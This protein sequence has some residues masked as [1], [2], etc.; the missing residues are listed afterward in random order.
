MNC[1]ACGFEN[2]DG[3]KFC[4]KCAAALVMSCPSC[5]SESP[6]G[7][8][9]CGSCGSPLTEAIPPSRIGPDMSGRSAQ[10]AAAADDPPSSFADGRY[11]VTKFLGEGG[12]KLVYLA[13]DDTLDRDVAFALI[14]TEGLDETSRT[15][16]TREAQAMGR[17]GTHPHVVTVFDLGEHD[18]QPYI[19]TELMG[20]GDV[21]GVIEDSDHDHLPPEQ[22][23]EIAKATCRGLE[24]AHSKGIVHRDLKP[25]NVWLTED[26]TA[27]I[28]D[29]G[30]AVAT[31]RSRLTQEGMMVGTVSYM[32]P[33]QAM[34]G[35]VT[36]QADL[37]SLG[38][39]LY[40]MVTG[41]PPFVGDDS[42][43]IIG[44][45][46]NTPPVAPTWHNPDVPPALE[47]LVLR[48]LEKDPASRPS[49]AAQVRESLEAIDVGAHG[50]APLPGD[51][52]PAGPDPTYRHTF[53][54]REAELRQLH[55]A[56]D[57][58]MSGEGSLVMVVGE[59][60]IGKTTICEQLET[61]AKLRGGMTL[62]GHCYEEGSL[63]LPY[64][65]FVEAMRSYVLERDADGL[66][67]DLGSGASEVARIVSE[68]RERLDV[69]PSDPGDPE[70]DRYRLMQSVTSFLTNAATVQPLVIVLEDLHDADRGT[71]DMLTHVSR[72][73]SG[74]RL[75]LIG[76]YRDVE[77][78]R[79]HPLSSALA[80]LRRIASFDRIGLRGL[81][82]DEVQR[83]MA[84]IAGHDIQWSI[85]EAVYRQTE[86][87]PLFVQ[88]VLRYLV[89]EG[90]LA[91][92]HDGSERQTPPEMRIPEG[93]LDVIGKRL[94]R[95]SQECN[96]VLGLAAV[97]GREFPVDVLQR[98]AGLADDDLFTALEEA[99]G[100][101]V[102][103]ERSAVGAV[104]SFRFTHAFFRQTLYE[105]TI[106]PRRIRLHQQVA[107]ALEE[108]YRVRP[109]EHAVELAEHFSYSSDASDLAKAIH[110]GELAADRAMAVYSYTEAVGH[111]ERALEVQEVLDPDDQAKRCDL[112]LA[113]GRAAIS[114]GQPMRVPETLAPEALDLAEA[115]GDRARAFAACRMAMDGL[116]MYG[117]GGLGGGPEWRP[118][119]ERA[120]ELAEPGTSERV[121]TD[122]A[123]SQMSLVERRLDEAWELR[124]G[125]LELARQLGEPGDISTAAMG[126]LTPRWAPKYQR[127]QS[128][129]AMELADIV[130]ELLDV[131]QG[132]VN[133]QVLIWAHLIAQGDRD[134]AET[135]SDVIFEVAER[136]QDPG[137]L[138]GSAIVK[139]LEATL[140]GRLEE[141]VVIAESIATMGEAHGRELAGI[142]LAAVVSGGLR[143][144]LGRAQEALEA[145]DSLPELLT[146]T[147]R[148]SV[149]A[150]LVAEVG[151]KAE[152]KAA[153]EQAVNEESTLLQGDEAPT[154]LLVTL[155]AAALIVNDRPTVKLAAGKL[156]A[157]DHLSAIPGALVCPARLLGGA[158][159]L[160]N[161]Q[162]EARELYRQALKL[163]EGMRNR[164]EVALT[165]LEL[166]ELLLDHYPDDPSTEP[167]LSS[168]KGSGQVR[169]EALEHLD[170]AITEL[171]DMKMQPALERALS[172]RE[173]LRA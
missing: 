152:A 125:A 50:R 86:G 11:Q 16:I 153:I 65:A 74:S 84:A 8:K 55:T 20:G 104:V 34:G 13:H 29:F 77:V 103:E 98:V 100:A 158:A 33:E 162:D 170:L 26:G 134:R 110:F 165:R 87:N 79:S 25:G 95:L 27:K 146:A 149:R 58:A 19:V 166:A 18:G 163:S 82:A 54:G 122:W 164:P 118:W 106:A 97:I 91:R 117:Q 80:E 70:Q 123:M 144:L 76:T 116:H 139:A 6:P 22:A 135:V 136:T 28:G 133:T 141:A 56:F 40:E 43:A 62:V 78:D 155:L 129:L 15:R 138:M 126:L 105:E 161:Q 37:Y 71:L 42:V 107:R 17:L 38:A 49:S 68:V 21:E 89:E 173:I 63:S 132:S 142:G 102:V 148:A 108:R 3:M 52:A 121:Y 69:D 47:T 60:G 72:N 169:A 75:M 51:A 93:L 124:Y 147:G 53:V 7:F 112:L 109:E 36:A 4:G 167:A 115:V 96:N 92:G 94:S 168:P 114:A 172:R 31:D 127:L 119:A 90:M 159:A 88:E 32:P 101:A 143:V 137:L 1:P 120:N 44:Q 150:R 160:Q 24:F 85:S 130:P 12:K 45:H 111:L 23:L 171:R 39:M 48:L 140:D 83:M 46:L 156:S 30:L 154:G 2:P 41:R 59:P 151:L 66:R 35:E 99:K 61:Y 157:L 5:G 10:D 113:L 73:L 131:S 14:K 81:T 9:F 67:S 128:A 145:W 57:K 64:L